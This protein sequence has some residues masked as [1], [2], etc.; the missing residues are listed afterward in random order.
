MFALKFCHPCKSRELMI[1]FDQ[2]DLKKYV[3]LSK[4][5]LILSGIEDEK[6]IFKRINDNFS[7]ESRLKLKEL[8]LIEGEYNLYDLEEVLNRRKE[9]TLEEEFTVPQKAEESVQRYLKRLKG[10][11][12]QMGE[13]A[14]SVEEFLSIFE[15]GIHPNVRESTRNLIVEQMKR[16]SRKSLKETFDQMD[17]A[18]KVI[19]DSSKDRILKPRNTCFC[20]KIKHLNCPFDLEEVEEACD[21]LI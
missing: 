19:A 13:D 12:P 1:E 17:G 16:L 9:L 10:L 21:D 14:P 20:C 11:L 15:K 7:E 3:K 18:L 8:G 4:M 6:E 2:K 5:T